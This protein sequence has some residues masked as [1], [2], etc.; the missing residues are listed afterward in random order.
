[1]CKIQTVLMDVAARTLGSFG[2][3]R[4]RWMIIRYRQAVPL[5]M[6]MRVLVAEL[7]AHSIDRLRRLQD[8]EYAAFS[9]CLWK[10]K[11]CRSCFVKSL[12]CREKRKKTSDCEFLLLV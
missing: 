10:K 12:L 8:L 11:M 1:M 5:V 4:Y 3:G 6:V 9:S 7:E 2:F